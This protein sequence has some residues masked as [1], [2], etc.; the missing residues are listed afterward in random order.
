MAYA[1]VPSIAP[2]GVRAGI[3]VKKN[4]GVR[5]SIIGKSRPGENERKLSS[6]TVE[7]HPLW[8][9]VESSISYYLALESADE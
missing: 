4:T 1:S 2:K 7:A 5:K 9:A 8:N 3:V 6:P